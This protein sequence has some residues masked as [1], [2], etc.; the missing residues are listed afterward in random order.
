MS[1]RMYVTAEFD[2]EEIAGIY[3]DQRLLSPPVTAGTAIVA[4]LVLPVSYEIDASEIDELTW[5]E[6]NRLVEDAHDQAVERSRRLGPG[7][8]VGK[9]FSMKLEHGTAWYVVTD[10]TASKAHVEWR[11]FGENRRRDHRLGWGGKFDRMIIQGHV[12]RHDAE[13][14]I[15]DAALEAVCA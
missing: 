3:F 6:A 15:A 13:Q 7:I 8:A 1:S 11:G 2:G 9:L 12:A 10:L 5:Y 14:A 4:D